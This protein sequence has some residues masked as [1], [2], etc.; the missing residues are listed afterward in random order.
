MVRGHTSILIVGCG[1]TGAGIARDLSL[2]GVECTVLDTNDYASGASGSNHGLLHSGARYAVKDPRAAEECVVES[3]ILKSIAPH[4]IEK[5]GGLFVGLPEDDEK[6]F[7]EFEQACSKTNIYFQALD[8]DYALELEPSLNSNIIA[9]YAVNDAT[10]DPFRLTLENLEDARIHGCT[11]LPYSKVTGFGVYKGRIENVRFIN[12]ISG[13]ESEIE[14]DYIINASGAWAG[15]IV[16]LTGIYIP[17][18]CSKGTLI[19]SASRITGAVVNR[20]RTPSDGDIIVPGGTVSIIGTTSSIIKD[21]DSAY[22]QP[23]ETDLLIEE[24]S[25]MVPEFAGSRYV[26]SYSGVRPLFDIGNNN[27]QRCI[28]R[29]Y[30][31][32]DHSDDGIDN[33]ATISGG[34]LTTY[35]LMAEKTADLVCSKL[36]IEAVC[37]TS[38][39]MLPDSRKTSWS[40]P[41]ASAKHHFVSSEK[42]GR[43]LCECEMISEHVIDEIVDDLLSQGREPTLTEIGLRSRVGKGPCQGCGCSSRIAAYLHG[44]GVFKG[45]DGINQIKAMTENRW[46]GLRPVVCGD[47]AAQLEL[48][49]SVHMGVFG[50]ERQ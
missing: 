2:R 24:A 37:K 42:G 31:L 9:A 49:E 4:C 45:R 47:S 38:T 14:A 11:F 22:P 29:G 50:L 20:L 6:Y 17:V 25:M 36:N 13:K 33:F 44:R 3:D 34:K 46:K 32:R 30:V 8:P 39:R 16:G 7:S 10:I 12:R 1:V 18:R 43:L 35:R 27:D 23:S 40:I 28:S 41:G 19:V 21:P 48:Q 26:R 5:T 15:K